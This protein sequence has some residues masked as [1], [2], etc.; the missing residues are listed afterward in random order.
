MD[1]SLNLPLSEDEP[2]PYIVRWWKHRTEYKKP[3]VTLDSAFNFMLDQQE[4]DCWVEG[5]YLDGIFQEEATI[6]A[7]GY[8]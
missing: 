4:T 5:I 1:S 7:R 8:E 6:K 2:N 3:F